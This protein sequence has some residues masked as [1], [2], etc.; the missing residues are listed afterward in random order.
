MMVG[1]LPDASTAEILLNN[2][3][4]ADFDLTQASVVMQDFKQRNALIP[5]GG[6]LQG[7]NLSTLLGRL[8]QTGLSAPDAQLCA[9][10]VAQGKVLIALVVPAAARPAAKEILRDH[11]AEFIRE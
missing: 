1:I 5:D 11:S 4:E 9:E 7:A 8:Q 6:P 10:A 2:L 3:A